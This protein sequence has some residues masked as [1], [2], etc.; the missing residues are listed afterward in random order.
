M[1]NPDPQPIAEH[2]SRRASGRKAT[3]KSE[4][5][6]QQILD[7]AAALFAERG[8]SLTRLSDIAERAGMH[9][10]GLYYYYDNKEELVSDIICHVPAR[11]A[12]GLKDA[13]DALPPSASKRQRLE[14]AFTVYLSYI[15][16]DDDYVRADHR[17]AAQISPEVRERAINIS[18]DI[19]AIWRTLLDEAAE[20]GEIRT[21]IDMTMLRM[22]MLGS[23]NWAVEWFRA[24]LSPPE[25]LAD[26]MK[27]LFFQGAGP[28]KI[29]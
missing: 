17:I 20:A 18:R 13:L 4:T 29:S 11:V 22:L 7:T 5:T 23:M 12:A 28:Q 9:L 15:L 1:D 25:R 14:T 3:R 2:V 24:D 26:A 6:R 27:V 21:D 8:Y 16:K 19:N 10:T